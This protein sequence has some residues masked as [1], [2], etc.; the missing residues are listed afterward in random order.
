MN[1][2]Q[3]GKASNKKFLS[4]IQ[5]DPKSISYE[6]IRGGVVNV[7]NEEERRKAIEDFLEREK[8]IML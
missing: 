1:W 2:I 7:K 8:N 4:H 5:L 6:G 3:V